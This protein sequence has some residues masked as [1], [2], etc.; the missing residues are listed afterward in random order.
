MTD[1]LERERTA[2]ARKAASAHA[3]LLR[4][5][6]AH[7]L[8]LVALSELDVRE[9]TDGYTFDCHHGDRTTRFYDYDRNGNPNGL[10]RHNRCK[11]WAHEMAF[12]HYLYKH[13]RG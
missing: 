8:A 10:D 13:P 12:E 9:E 3:A 4:A 5:E 7:R 2:R 6:N 1:T 11:A